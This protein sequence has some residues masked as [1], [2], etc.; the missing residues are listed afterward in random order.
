MQR[1]DEGTPRTQL[2]LAILQPLI[3][4]FRETLDELGEAG[5]ID[6]VERARQTATWPG[7]T[8]LARHWDKHRRGS[9]SEREYAAWVEATKNKPGVEVYAFVHMTTR[10]RGLAFVDH[11]DGAV[12]WFDVERMCNVSGFTP[13]EGTRRFLAGKDHDYWRLKETEL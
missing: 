3:A 6:L 2:G 8:W 9:Q 5:R 4:N 10:R 13:T 12:I 1:A 11:R 7:G